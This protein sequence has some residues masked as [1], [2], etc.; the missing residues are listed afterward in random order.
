M[1]PLTMAKAGETVTIKKI[2]GKDE[3]R[4]HLAELGFVVESEVTV[5]NEIAGNLILQVKESRIALHKTMANRIM[6][7]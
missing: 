5:V 4:Q 6:S 3:I 7:G 2:T 1:M